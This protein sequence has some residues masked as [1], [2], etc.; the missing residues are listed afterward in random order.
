MGT[1]MTTARSK[2][3]TITI[4]KPETLPRR[5]RRSAASPRGAVPPAASGTDASGLYRLLAWLSPSYPVGAFSYSSGLEWAVESRDVVDAESLLRWI[6]VVLESGGGVCDGVIFVH[7][8]RIAADPDADDAP[9]RARNS[10]RTS[11]PQRSPRPA[12]F[13]T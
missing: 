4:M 13:P 1:T 8:H 3:R 9:L 10:P 12:A 7:A 11:A 2:H 5:G 6:T